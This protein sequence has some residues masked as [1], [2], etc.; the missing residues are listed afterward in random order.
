MSP[1]ALGKR[2]TAH[3]AVDVVNPQL[4]YYLADW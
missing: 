2:R 4:A 3:D 1:L